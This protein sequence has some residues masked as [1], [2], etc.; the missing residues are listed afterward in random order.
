MSYAGRHRHH[1]IYKLGA[2]AP[3]TRCLSV[4]GV[5]TGSLPY[6]SVCPCIWHIAAT[7]LMLLLIH[8]LPSVKPCL[9]ACCYL[10]LTCYLTFVCV[11]TVSQLD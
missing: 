10:T 8:C 5:S 11:R 9:A 4:P 3:S 1:R 7:P 2:W 6:A